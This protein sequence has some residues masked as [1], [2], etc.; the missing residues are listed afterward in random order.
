MKHTVDVIAGGPGREAEISQR[1]AATIYQHLAAAGYDVHL[2]TIEERLDLSAC[3]PDAIIFNIVHGTYGEDGQLQAELEQ[4]GRLYVGSDAVCS[5]LCMDKD[6]T[7]DRLSHADLPVAWGRRI[8]PEHVHDPN[9]FK[10]FPLV[11]LV[12]KPC[13]DGSSVGLR[14][15]S[16]VSFLLPTLEELVADLGAIPF[17]VE[18][19]LRGAEYTVAVIDNPD[20]QPQVLPPME[21]AAANGSY[22]FEAKYNRNDTQYNFVSDE[23]LIRSLSDLASRAYA[24]CGC[25]DLARIDI[26]DRGDGS[27]A[28][29]EVNTLP[30][31]TDHSLVPKAAAEAGISLPQLVAQLVERAASREGLS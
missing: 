30:G 13:C 26:M 31:F 11:P 18:E 6:A 22:D 3:R 10:G 4:A 2:V 19:R 17:L 24:A 14:M 7:K 25:R 29:L 23:D 12:V 8:N 16:S 28:I 1:S 9:I 5:R 21:I 15:L 20:G 27:L